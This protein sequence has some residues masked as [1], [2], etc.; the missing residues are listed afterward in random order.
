MSAVCFENIANF[1]QALNILCVIN[2]TKCDKHIRMAHMLCLEVVKVNVKAEP[3]AL[4]ITN[5]QGRI[6]V[7]CMSGRKLLNIV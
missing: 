3:D 6:L 5:R 4:R 7:L 2:V 1:I